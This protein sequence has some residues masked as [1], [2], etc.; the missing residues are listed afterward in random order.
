MFDGLAVILY[1]AVFLFLF[2][3]FWK[4]IS[5]LISRIGGWMKMAEYFATDQQ[6]K[7]QAFRFVSAQFGRFTS[8]S[9]CLNISVSTNGIYLTPI[10]LFR[11][12]HQPLFIPW[13]AVMALK[14]QGLWRFA[15]VRLLI[16][17]PE[18]Q[19]EVAIS[20]FGQELVD[21]LVK[22]APEHLQPR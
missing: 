3:W 16:R 10:F 13:Q 19:R 5:W 4:G 9:R 8:Y 21:S 15:S 2:F 22:Q 11:T 6:A 1:M 7:G 17:L 20:L 18:G 12:G 14:S